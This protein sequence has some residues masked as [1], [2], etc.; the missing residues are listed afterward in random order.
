MAEASSFDRIATNSQSVTRIKFFTRSEK[1]LSM[2]LRS[3]K[4]QAN[5]QKTHYK[6]N[7][8]KPKRG[9]DTSIAVLTRLRSQTKKEEVS[10]KKPS[11]S[12]CKF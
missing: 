11:K 2:K 6:R 3:S 5:I 10:V 4:S 7:P 9:P 1:S 8:K 12:T